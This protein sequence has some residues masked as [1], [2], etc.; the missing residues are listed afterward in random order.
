MHKASIHNMLMSQSSF[1]A[2]RASKRLF[3]TPI[4]V[5]F[6]RMWCVRCGSPHEYDKAVNGGALSRGT[7]KTFK[8][9]SILLGCS[10]LR[11]RISR[12][13]R[14]G[15][16]LYISKVMISTHSVSIEGVKSE[17][18]GLDSS[19]RLGCSVLHEWGP[20]SFIRLQPPKS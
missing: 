9:T 5:P 17:R 10:N 3:A 20:A 6:S 12:A 1:K 18:D 15:T 8:R 4:L 2:E 14:R 7:T 11:S 16:L 19:S 13:R